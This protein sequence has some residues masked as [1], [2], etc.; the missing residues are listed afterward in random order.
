M[1]LMRS[2]LLFVASLT[3]SVV[4]A[5]VG[6]V[7]PSFDP[8]DLSGGTANGLN[9][10]CRTIVVQ[11]D[12]KILVAGDFGIVNGVERPRIARL[13]A[14]GSLDLGFD[15]GYGANAGVR[16]LAVQPDGKIL[17]GGLFTYFN[18]LFCNH[19][20]RLNADGSLD[21]GFEM[22]NGFDGNVLALAVQPDGGIL[23]G[24]DF[25]H[26][27]NVLGRGLV[28]LNTD[29]SHDTS[30]DGGDIPI[31]YALALRPDGRIIVGG[32]F[33]FVGGMDRKGIAAV[34]ADGSL[35]Q[36]FAP[37][38]WNSCAVFALALQ[39]DGK[40]VLGGLIPGGIARLEMNGEVDPSYGSGAA[41]FGG[42]D[43]RVYAL[44]LQPDGR[45]LAAGSFSSYN[46]SACNGMARLTSEGVLDE[47]F[48][49]GEGFNGDVFAMALQ[50]D[51]KPLVGGFFDS[52]DG[53][54]RS[55]IARLEVEDMSTGFTPVNDLSLDIYPNPSSGTVFL[56]MDTRANASLSIIGPD[57][58]TARTPLTPATSAGLWTIDLS[59]Y[60]KGIYLVR[61]A[62]GAMAR[63]ERV[64]I[65]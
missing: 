41:G 58:R 7:D 11:P 54:P 52:V 10:S 5:Q 37:L 55:R 29:G 60:A 51:G 27:N 48:F 2:P 50:A 59:A 45:V 56:R 64:V 34:Y 46:G 19:I 28:R 61:I 49:I 31:V 23:V 30:F 22:G 18:G 32:T 42:W 47:S 36:S 3:G 24:G 12:G 33:S 17:V 57:G 65:Q 35:D 21:E 20:V 4:L 16:A 53:T 40:V 43:P 39:A 9:G 1:P 62:E 25:Y 44:A 8:I 38:G 6:S 26:V 14:D 63:T 13:E 15:P